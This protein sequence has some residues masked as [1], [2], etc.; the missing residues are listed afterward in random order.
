MLSKITVWAT[1]CCLLII[2]G[3]AFAQ[4]VGPV[5]DD[6]SRLQAEAFTAP[7]VTIGPDFLFAESLSAAT[8]I[9]MS[10]KII[11]PGGI[12]V[13]DEQTNASSLTVFITDLNLSDGQYRYELQST[14]DA[15][16]TT[17]PFGGTQAGHRQYGSFQILDGMIEP[18]LQSD[19]SA[20][21]EISSTNQPSW[22]V[23][24]AGVL[25]DLLVPS[26]QAQDVIVDGPTPDLWWHDTD[27]GLCCDWQVH[28]HNFLATNSWGL[29]DWVGGNAGHD[30]LSIYGAD[31][32]SS[33]SLSLVVDSAGD[34]TL[35]S[36]SVFIDR[37]EGGMHIGS[38]T[39][40]YGP[41]QVTHPSTS[42]W[43]TLT[44]A[45]DTGYLVQT[46]DTLALWTT[47][48]IRPFAIDNDAP[49]NSLFIN[50]TG[51]IGF[52]T[53]LPSEAVD[54][55]RSA[56]AARFQL[57]S[58]SDTGNEAPQFVQRRAL[59]P[60][61]APAAVTAGDNLGLFSF[62]GYTGTGFSGTKAGITVKAT[63]P[64]SGSANGTRML[65]Q[66]TTNGTTALNTV[67][68]IT[69]DSKVKINGTELS[70]PDYVFEE[71]YQLMPLEELDS[72][73]REHKHLPGV[74][75][76]E[77]VKREG[78]DLGGSQLSVLEKVEE[79]TL[80]TL[81]QHEQLKALRTE[82]A[83]LR[84]AY[85]TLQTRIAK[86]DQLEQMVNLLLQGEK[87]SPLLTSVSE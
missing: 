43:I 17:L 11:A 49:N 77:E 48:S 2:I 24:I 74:A 73:I 83:Q 19:I 82:N 5:T 52:G 54:V 70:V 20:E 69:H 14:F 36:G 61:F 42:S 39:A 64:W 16:A 38:T 60:S 76:A 65:F 72:F 50:D 4:N 21:E 34:M 53:E 12:V 18:E 9:R 46:A 31:G 75:S 10:V 85:G 71:D 45:A 80:Y 84:S 27:G 59:G 25:L 57:T 40:P 15:G 30:V 26:A 3:Q 37:S 28:A 22:P 35:A 87:S 78:L 47:D 68:E 51:N 8:P 86:V 62:R 41:L 23:Q 56:A 29:G 6:G 67:M 55:E 79:L 81:Q 66:T 58:F 7:E 63:E 13:F 33:N 1:S 32:S 44:S